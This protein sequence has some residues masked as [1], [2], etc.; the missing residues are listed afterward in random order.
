MTELLQDT[1]LILFGSMLLSLGF[2]SF[3]QPPLLGYILAGLLIG[4]AFGQVI[5]DTS[6]IKLLGEFGMILLLFLIGLELSLEEFRKVWSSTLICLLIQILGSLLIT[7]LLSY[8]LNWNLAFSLFLAFNLSLSSTA[9]VVTLLENMNLLGSKKGSFAIS[10]LI[11]QDLSLM[12]MLLILRTLNAP[13]VSV[14]HFMNLFLA[15]GL[16]II[17]V[18]FFGKQYPETK[19][20]LIYRQVLNRP[21]I[22]TLIGASLCFAFA[23]L[24]DFFKLSAAYGSF[25]AGL[26]LGNKWEKE[27]LLQSFVPITSMMMMVFFISVGMRLSPE[28]IRSFNFYE[29]IIIL[30]VLF[31]VLLSK[32]T[33]NLIGLRLIKWPWKSAI[34]LAV[35]MAQLSE[36]SFVLI[37][38]ASTKLLIN[39]RST[40]LFTAVTTLSLAFGSVL[41]IAVRWLQERK[42]TN[43]KLY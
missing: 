8:Y 3:G 7:S 16:L 24:A 36:F 11:A 12:P 31:F 28:Y 43:S 33:V 17:S 13:S 30:I 10:L 38:E 41:P 1:S 19:K 9:V 4:P 23:S 6:N 42:K 35:L 18:I 15:I 21:E 39:Y 5:E 37:D 25:L 2:L 20:G 34:F 27:L 26:M 22:T 40:Q 14:S 29:L 32:F